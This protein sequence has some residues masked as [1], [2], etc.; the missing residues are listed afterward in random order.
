M[1]SRLLFNNQT[2]LVE[3]YPRADDEPIVGLDRE[4]YR[5]LLVVQQP[6][7]DHDQVTEAI[8]PTEAITWDSPAPDVD[9]TMTRGW[10][11]D[12]IEPPPPIP[13]G[14]DWLGFAGWLYGFPAMAA[15]MEAARASR[16]PQGEPATTGLPTAMDEARLRANYIPFAISWALFLQA[17]GLSGDDLA[18]IIAKASTCNLPPEF[19]AALEGP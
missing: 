19:V 9:G 2:Q 5:V 6:Q 18:E 3:P 10:R 15:A 16:D 1:N 4:R 13:P 8:T 7:P 11:V 12:P 17:G 14:P